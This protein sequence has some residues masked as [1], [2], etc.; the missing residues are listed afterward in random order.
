MPDTISA[1]YAALVAAGE[2]ERDPAQVAVVARLARLNE[3][4]AA[5]RLGTKVVLARLAVRPAH[6]RANLS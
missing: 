1:R 6:D 2:V 4:L 3:R 5:H